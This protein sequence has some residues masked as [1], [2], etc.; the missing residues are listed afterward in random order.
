MVGL[1]HLVHHLVIELWPIAQHGV[2]SSNGH[3]ALELVTSL[4][5]LARLAAVWYG[6]VTHDD[7]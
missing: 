6:E 5:V 2:T 4:T 1:G 3:L 7:I